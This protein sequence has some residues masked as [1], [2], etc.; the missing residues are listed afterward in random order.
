MSKLSASMVVDLVDKT[1]GKTKAIIGNLNRL[2]RAERDFMLADRGARLS[3]RD[4]AME[5][6][7][8]AREASI[9]ERQQRI[10]TW[11]ARGTAAVTVASVAAGRAVVDY[12]AVERQLT[13]IGITS[14]ASVEQ[15]SDAF[16]KLQNETQRLAL[17]AQEGI[18]ALDTLVASGMELGEAMNFLPAV[19]AAA[20]A[21]GAATED[22]A[23]TAVK[24]AS[25]LKLAGN[26]MEL[27]F[28]KMV[29]GG[30]LGQFEL[31]DMAQYI[32]DLANSFASLGYS[33]QDG[34]ARLLAVLQTLRE[35]TGSASSAATQAQNIFGKMFSEET[36]N[37]FKK[38]GIDLRSEMQAAARS[39][40]DALSAFVRLSKQAL[41][42][43]LT[44]LPQLFADQEF[45]LGMQ[46]LITSPDSLE[47]FIKA[48][49]SAEVNGAVW[50]DVNRVLQDTQS[51]IDKLGNSYERLRN[52]A[53]A[54]IAEPA[55]QVMDSISKEL[56]FNTAAQAGMKKRGWSWLRRQMGFTVGGEHL[57]LAYEGGYRDPDF[58]NRY[59]AYRYGEGK[60]ESSR[61]RQNARVV[62][63]D[64]PGGDRRLDPYNLPNDVAVPVSREQAFASADGRR[65][66]GKPLVEDRA[67][68][69]A[70]DVVADAD[71]NISLRSHQKTGSLAQI[72]RLAGEAQ[73]T[74]DKRDQDAAGYFDFLSDRRFWVRDGASLKDALKID[75]PNR[76][77]IT[78]SKR[79]MEWTVDTQPKPADSPTPAAAASQGPQEVS[80]SGTPT[81]ITQPSGV[82]QVQ[83]TN[84]PPPPNLQVSVVV[85]A[86]SSA[87]PRAIGEQVGQEVGRKVRDELA[88]IQAD[89]GWAVG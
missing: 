27:A 37:R 38:F 21:S 29:T 18:K 69:I 52:S 76:A 88:G 7:M 32:P 79:S 26:E 22:I 36:G 34:L 82:Q 67:Q 13:R 23:N 86:N 15:M 8:I 2:E 6:M 4:R 11:I 46:S 78:G 20:Q 75:V 56:D 17:P 80:L 50:R 85:H 49:N 43:D 48:L 40:E 84:Q 45:R 31:R 87:D 14:G 60:V 89:T 10:N 61:G 47:R 53:G 83:V 30:K 24:T 65:S 63:Q 68:A 59:W 58:M 35:D 3:N 55:S 1:G 12:A 70:D 39:G 72:E 16:A 51:N 81:V 28:D 77:P 57:D 19:L 62:R 44:K 71:G 74:D 25:A 33:G 5:R 73:S 54:A 64:F 42:G 9:E 41:N 66:I